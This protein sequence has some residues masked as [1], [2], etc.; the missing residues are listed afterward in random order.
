MRFNIYDIIYSQCSQQHVSADITA[1]LRV[2]LLQYKCTNVVSCVAV[3]P[4][5]LNIIIISVK[6]I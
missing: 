5:Q 6:I 2:I 3:T 4:K 1:I